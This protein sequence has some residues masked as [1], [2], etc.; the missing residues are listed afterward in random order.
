V[1]DPEQL[2]VLQQGPEAWNAWRKKARIIFADLSEAKLDGADLQGPISAELCST[3]PTWTRP[4]FA[5]WIL[6]G[7]ISSVP[8]SSEL[9]V[10]CGVPLMRA[11]FPNPN[12]NGC[13]DDISSAARWASVSRAAE[14]ADES[15]LPA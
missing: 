13:D 10:L 14:H 3:G 8:V 5:R 4:I 11:G 6:V 15:R 9:A 1:A 2:A 7:L 12:H